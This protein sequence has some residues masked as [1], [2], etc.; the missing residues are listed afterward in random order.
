MSGRERYSETYTSVP[1]RITEPYL[2]PPL[3]ASRRGYRRPPAAASAGVRAIRRTV[4]VLVVLLVGGFAAVQTQLFG[5]WPQVVALADGVFGTSHGPG[6][7][8]GAEPAASATPSPTPSPE[9]TWEAPDPTAFVPVDQATL[10]AVLDTPAAHADRPLLA[11]AVVLQAGGF[12]TTAVPGL[13]AFFVTLSADRPAEQ[14]EFPTR[15]AVLLAPTSSHADI[16]EGDL[17]LVRLAVP[18]AGEEPVSVYSQSGMGVPELRLFAAEP[19]E[20]ADLVADVAIGEIDRSGELPVLRVAVRNSTSVTMSYAIDV[21]ALRGDGSTATS[22]TAWSDP[23]P[24]G[25]TGSADITL[26]GELPDGVT[27]RVDEVHRYPG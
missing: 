1:E 27:F 20:Y 4:L 13:R 23:I 19:T 5:L 6:T 25:Q 8:P 17:L 26:H 24:G 18:P 10:D 2:I 22:T 7:A 14:Y 16:A 21:T 11:Y 15:D 3:E 9:P 12:E